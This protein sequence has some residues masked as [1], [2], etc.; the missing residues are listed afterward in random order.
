[1]ITLGNTTTKRLKIMIIED[2]EDI[3]ILYND[4]LI[5]KGHQVINKYLS[6]DSIITDIE[7]ETPDVYLIDYRLPGNKNGIDVAIE[8][9]SRYPSA[10]IVFITAFELLDREITKHSIFY[11]KNIDVLIK[12]IKLNEIEKSMLDLVNKN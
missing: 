3:L 2:E 1:V 10:F 6:A 4:Y 8:I 7:K 9:L 11:D 12:P 5:S